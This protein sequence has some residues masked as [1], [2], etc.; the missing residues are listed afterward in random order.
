MPYRRDG[1][2]CARCA[3]GQ[4]CTLVKMIHEA[5]SWP[6]PKRLRALAG[7]RRIKSFVAE[8]LCDPCDCR[9]WGS[10]FSLDRRYGVKLP[11]RNERGPYPPEAEYWNRTAGKIQGRSAWRDGAGFR[12][13][14]ILPMAGGSA[15][16]PCASLLVHIPLRRNGHS[17]SGARVIILAQKNGTAIVTLCRE[18]KESSK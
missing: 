18:Q 5:T 13:L 12:G 3:T 1:T 7:Y 14:D 4:T 16:C 6:V 9:S 11:A 15:A 10:P 17:A 8:G 2:T